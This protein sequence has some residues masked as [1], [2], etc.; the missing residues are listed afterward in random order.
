MTTHPPPPERCRRA[1]CAA[2]VRYTGSYDDVYGVNGGAID[3][4]VD[5]TGA[6]GITT[7]TGTASTRSQRLPRS[8]QP[9][10]LDELCPRHAS[11]Y[12]SSR[13]TPTRR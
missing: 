6:A 3:G 5:V 9:A 7:T 13:A 1:S 4:G 11:Y 8:R 10:F 12:F 2:T